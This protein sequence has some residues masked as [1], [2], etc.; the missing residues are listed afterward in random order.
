MWRSKSHVLHE[1]VR[2]S[3]PDWSAPARVRLMPNS[4]VPTP[5]VGIGIAARVVRLRT[6][7]PVV[8]PITVASRRLTIAHRP[9]ST[10]CSASR[11]LS[12]IVFLPAPA[13][14]G[15]EA[16]GGPARWLVVAASG[17]PGG[18]VRPMPPSR[19]VVLAGLLFSGDDGSKKTG[20][21]CSPDGRRRSPLVGSTPSFSASFWQDQQLPA[22][23]VDAITRSRRAGWA[24]GSRAQLAEGGQPLCS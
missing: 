14:P 8:R 17:K 18:E 2:R 11:R 19:S 23:D 15:E 5:S 22:V 6:Y 9:R 10:P 24:C 13:P 21:T 16:E 1:L 4:V 12:S 20:A 3:T 7:M